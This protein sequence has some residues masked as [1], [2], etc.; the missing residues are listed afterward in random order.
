MIYYRMWN[1]QAI[2]KKYFDMQTKKYAYKGY[3]G[4]D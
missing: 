1:L 4:E 2:I 3:L